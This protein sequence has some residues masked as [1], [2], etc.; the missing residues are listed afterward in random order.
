MLDKTQSLKDVGYSFEQGRIHFSF[1]RALN[2]GD[3][4]DLAITPSSQHII[5]ALSGAVPHSPTDWSR[6][7]TKGSQLLDLTARSQCPGR[8]GDRE[9]A[10]VLP[11]RRYAGS[12]T[13]GPRSIRTRLLLTLPSNLVFPRGSWCSWLPPRSMVTGARNRM[14][15]GALVTLCCRLAI[16]SLRASLYFAQVIAYTD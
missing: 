9:L 8:Q 12:L 11:K 1:K 6:H 5:W 16:P 7:K 15:P 10:I 3:S 4:Q 2:T 13:L 14:T